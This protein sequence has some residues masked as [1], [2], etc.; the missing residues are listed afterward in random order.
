VTS[1]RHLWPL[2]ITLCVSLVPTLQY[3]Y[4]GHPREASKITQTS[5]PAAVGGLAGLP[6]DRTGGWLQ[7]TYGA[8][9][10]AERT[11]NVPGAGSIGLFVARGFDMKKLYHHPELGVMRGHQF[12][13]QRTQV[14]DGDA[15]QVVHV[16]QG[17]AGQES[18]AYVLLYDGRWVSNPYALQLS[19]AVT[20]LW[21]GPR[22]L[23]LIFAY[24]A[25]LAN[26]QPSSSTAELLRRTAQQLAAAAPGRP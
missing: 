26:G 8:D 15:D 24:G 7:A 3:G 5:L 19:S 13:P 9:S 10:W 16:L 22:P 2:V 20:T 12:E 1:R 25:V 23:T 17:A 6:K 14:L 21:T 11:Y 4:D 18:A